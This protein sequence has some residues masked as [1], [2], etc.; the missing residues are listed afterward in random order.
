[1]RCSR[2][3]AASS[4]VL[5]AAL[6]APIHAQ[7][8]PYDARALRIESNFWGARLLQG[9]RAEKV[10]GLGMFPGPIL[11]LQQS[12]DSVRKYHDAFR[13]KEALGSGL[14]FGMVGLIVA[15]SI[16]GLDEAPGIT[17]FLGGVVTGLAS[18]MVSQAAGDD[19]NRAVWWYNR[20]LR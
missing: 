6:G 11:V 7:D 18:I 2:R 9:S 8:N 20:E 5:L 16:A 3:F 17:L 14:F 19:L 15:G 13:S 4:A 10:A 12:T 1:M